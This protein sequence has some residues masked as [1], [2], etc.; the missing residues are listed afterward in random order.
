M[1]VVAIS[2]L[3]IVKEGKMEELRF[4]SY[5]VA[6]NIKQSEISELLNI[7]V[8]NVNEKINGKQPWTLE[9][10]KIIC[11]HYNISADEYFI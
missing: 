1:Y 10:V 6:H 8:P 9:Q 3:N 5:C 11:E 4:K 2:Q 7:T